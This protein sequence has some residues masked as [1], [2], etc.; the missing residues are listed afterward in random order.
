MKTSNFFFK[1]VEQ[2]YGFVFWSGE[3]I[4]PLGEN[5]ISIKDEE[6]DIYPNIEAYFTNTKLATKSMDNEDE[7]T[8]FK[9]LN[10]SG[11]F[12][13]THTRGFHSAKMK[14]ASYNLLK[15][16]GQIQNPPLP[17]IENIEDSPK[18]YLMMIFKVM[19]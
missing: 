13:M 17:T 7:L 8:L 19:D 16:I 4:K 15:A 12:S 11:L 18:K 14:D 1:L 10:K 6:S 2:N 5:R 3:N 9:I